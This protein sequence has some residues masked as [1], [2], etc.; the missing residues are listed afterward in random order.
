MEMTCR[1]TTDYQL[2]V[3][4]SA[5]RVNI[6]GLN[7]VQLIRALWKKQAVSAHYLAHAIPL[8]ELTDDKIQCALT[9][10]YVYFLCGKYIEVDFSGNEV[11]SAAYNAHAG[12]NAMETVVQNLRE[13]SV[14]PVPRVVRDRRLHGPFTL[15]IYIS[16]CICLSVILMYGFVTHCIYHAPEPLYCQA[17]NKEF[18]QDLIDNPMPILVGLF[19][20]TMCMFL[21]LLNY[22]GQY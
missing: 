16:F 8:P 2:A 13:S 9:E 19:S 3:T 12:A 6:Q 18:S 7:K 15:I 22:I 14:T 20:A 21:S 1:L 11:D 10:V 4:M 17:F 5:T